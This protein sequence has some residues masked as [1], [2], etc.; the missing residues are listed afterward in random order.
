VQWEVL[1]EAHQPMF[2][3][4]CSCHLDCGFPWPQ[5][6][7]H[8]LRKLCRNLDDVQR[9]VLLEA[10]FAMATADG[11]MAVRCPPNQLRRLSAAHSTFWGAWCEATC[12]DGDRFAV[13]G[14]QRSVAS[15]TVC[16]PVKRCQVRSVRG[17]CLFRL[18]HRML[19]WT[20]WGGWRWR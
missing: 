16:L 20:S 13:A 14:A 3:H 4:V 8:K 5:G 18:L 17:T 1:P 11:I 19:R 12:H 15:H 10:T 7:E 6:I 9:E 2:I